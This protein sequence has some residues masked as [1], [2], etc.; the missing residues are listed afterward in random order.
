MNLKLQNASIVVL[1]EG[2][3]PKLLSHDFLAR[4]QIVPEDWQIRDIVVTPPFS[5]ILYENGVQFIVEINKLQIRANNPEL[6]DWERE[7]PA[8]ASKYLELLPHVTYRGVGINFVYF[9]ENFPENPFERLL[10]DGPWLNREG[11]LTGASVELSYR[12]ETPQFNVKIERKSAPGRESGSRSSLV[13][14]VNYHHDFEPDQERER[15]EYIHTIARLRDRF[16]DY[17]KSLPFKD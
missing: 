4:N 16:L 14:S 8:M 13:F 1:S 5:Q 2:N 17:A 6:I 11:G 12:E 7:L 15:V 3:N 9:S 10:W